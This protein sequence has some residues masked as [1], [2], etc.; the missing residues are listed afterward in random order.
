MRFLLLF[1]M[2]DVR[3]ACKEACGF[4]MRL[5][6]CVEFVEGRSDRGLD[7]RLQAGEALTLLDVE[8]EKA[9]ADLEVEAELLLPDISEV[10]Y[11]YVGG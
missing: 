6:A 11:K 9:E 4:R 7:L 3:V 5:G 8:A 1:G 2:C 10:T